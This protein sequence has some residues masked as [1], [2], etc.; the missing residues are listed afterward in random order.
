MIG[1]GIYGY[2]EVNSPTERVSQF[3][4]ELRRDQQIFDE[5]I[6]NER[7]FL[8]SLSRLAIK[9]NRESRSQVLENFESYSEFVRKGALKSLGHFDDPKVNSFLQAKIDSY[10]IA[11]LKALGTKESTDRS[12]MLKNMDTKKFS[13]DEL[14]YYHLALF[15][16]NSLFSEKKVILNFLIDQANNL[17]DGELLEDIVVSLTIHVPNFEKFHELLRDKLFTSNSDLIISRSIKHLSV[18]DKG[19]LK[20]QSKRVFQ[21][22]N[23]YLI[24]EYLNRAGAF[25]PLGIWNLLSDNFDF[26]RELMVKSAYLLNTKKATDL[27]KLKENKSSDLYKKYISKSSETVG[28]CY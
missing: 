28:L 7:E 5:A 14:I 13:Q 15:K 27:L 3:D 9:G 11:S 4:A 2:V 20:V 21:T 12:K 22:N 17:D 16:T 6:T 25:C 23:R 24:G 18:Y 26:D 8:S 19:W 10:P 1:A